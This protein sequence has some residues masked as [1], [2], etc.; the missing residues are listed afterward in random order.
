MDKSTKNLITLMENLTCILPANSQQNP[1]QN[2]LN[3][4]L[5]AYETLWRVVLRLLIETLFRHGDKNGLWKLCL[6]KLSQKL[7]NGENFS[8]HA[9]VEGRLCVLDIVNEGLRLYPPTKRIYR[10]EQ[11][12]NQ[13]RCLYEY[14]ELCAADIE[15]LHRDDKVWG[16]DVL[17]FEPE[18]WSRYSAAE[19]KRAMEQF[20]PFGY[21]SLSCPAKGDF[22]PKMIALLVAVLVEEI[23][24]QFEWVATLEKDRVDGVDPLKT[25]RDS[26][27]TLELKRLESHTM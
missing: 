5:P 3:I 9:E 12:E 15:A 24:S 13:H 10:W 11:R 8:L 27:D 20:I 18:R 2:P 22:A 7:D 16:P 21:G 25:Q 26:Y 14:P 17:Q 6:T 23:G 4:I 1:R 19:R